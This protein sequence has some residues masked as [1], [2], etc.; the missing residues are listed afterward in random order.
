[1]KIQTQKSTFKMVPEGEQELVVTDVKLVPSGKPQ[2]VEFHYKHENGATLRERFDFAHP[3]AMTI[4][5]KRCDIALGGS[6]PEGTEIDSSDLPEMF[7]DKAV[8]AQVVHK[9]GKDGRT[10]ANISYLISVEGGYGAD[11]DL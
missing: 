6:V 10:Y 5:G 3:I 2:M 11:D 8:V 7:L 4:L 9:E 1:M